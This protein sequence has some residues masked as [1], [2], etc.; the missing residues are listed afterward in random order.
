MKYADQYGE[1]YD[2][3][4]VKDEYE[5]GGLAVIAYCEDGP[6]AV[7]TTWLPDPVTNERCAYLDTNNCKHLVE[8]LIDKGYVR[9]TYRYA[10]SGF[11]EYPEG[12]FDDEFLS[13]L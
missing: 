3:T 1:T 10:R 4:F 6:Y 13:T 11:C 9:Q 7:V 2:L 5:L 12:M 8:W